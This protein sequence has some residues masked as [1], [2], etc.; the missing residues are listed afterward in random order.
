MQRI[1]VTGGNKGI[2]LAIVTAVL[3]EHDDTFVFLGSRDVARG[4]AAKR[5]LLEAHPGWN[6]R[7][8]VVE[9]DVTGDTS[10]SR[11]A[12]KVSELC[13]GERL[14]GLVNNAGVGGSK[15][16]AE[17]LATNTFGMRRVCEA[18]LP[19]LEPRGGRIVN[20]TSASGPNFVA[21][22]SEQ[23]QKFF[24]NPNVEWAELRALLDEC[25]ALDGDKEAFAKRGLGD[26]DPYGLSK[27]AANS[28]TLLLARRHPELH[29]NAC[30]PGFIETDLTRGYATAKGKSPADLGMRPPADGARAP[31]Y[32]LF[33]ELEGNGRYYGSDAK[34]SPLDRYRSPGSEPYTGD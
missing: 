15:P 1:L 4:Q 34:R 32:L 8:E 9:L 23:R 16:L 7:V 29:V 3:D 31:L 6:S 13:G 5:H 33:S 2:G 20:I 12:E 14:Y 25:V 28:Y 17:V 27:A 22:C 30:T 18:L 26:G 11:M 10:V 21:K 24:V 19:L